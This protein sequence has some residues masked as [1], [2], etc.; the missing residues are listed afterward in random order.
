MLRFK[1]NKLVQLPETDMKASNLLEKND[2]S[3]GDCR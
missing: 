3:T 2:S 1:D